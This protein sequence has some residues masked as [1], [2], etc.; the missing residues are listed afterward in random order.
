MELDCQQNTG[1]VKTR[2]WCTDLDMCYVTDRR[3]KG[4]PLVPL[5]NINTNKYLDVFEIYVVHDHQQHTDWIRKGRLR[6]NL[7]LRFSPDRSENGQKVWF[8]FKHSS[9]KE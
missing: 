2:V 9:S 7:D 5:N 1:K 4:Q 8:P 3:K 6:I